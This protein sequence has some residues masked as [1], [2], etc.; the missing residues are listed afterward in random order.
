M[1][2]L[3]VAAVWLATRSAA[4]RVRVPLSMAT[5]T[6]SSSAG[7]T[8]A[9][10]F[11]SLGWGVGHP[12]AGTTRTEPPGDLDAPVAEAGADLLPGALR[13]DLGRD[14]GAGGD[15]R[16]GLPVVEHD[17]LPRLV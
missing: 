8:S 1:S 11:P 6:G 2:A 10:R 16:G 15:Q 17:R 4:R 13:R 12:A 5:V 14:D 3:L 7:C 9:I